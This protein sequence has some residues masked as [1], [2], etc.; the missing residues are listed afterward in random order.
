MIAFIVVNRDRRTSTPPPQ[1]RAWPTHC[2]RSQHRR[3]QPHHAAGSARDGRLVDDPR[4]GGARRDA[5][6]GRH[7][8]A[9]RVDPGACPV[10][11]GRRSERVPE[12]PHGTLRGWSRGCRCMWCTAA[13]AATTVG[14]GDPTRPVPGVQSWSCTA[15]QTRWAIAVVSPSPQPNL[16]C[17]ATT[18]EQ[19]GRLSGL[20]GAGSHPRR[21]CGRADRLG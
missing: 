10:S 5:A 6:E 13:K 12:A 21:R 4:P 16:D 15:C 1:A 2:D 9:C 17:L 19:L 8:R 11:E 7:D 18:I 20:L 14:A 3:R